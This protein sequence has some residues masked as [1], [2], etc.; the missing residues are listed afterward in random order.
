ME[1]RDDVARWFLAMVGSVLSQSLV[2]VQV[3]HPVVQLLRN[4]HDLQYRPPAKSADQLLDQLVDVG[5][6]IRLPRPDKTHSWAACSRARTGM[7]EILLLFAT[8]DLLLR[9]TLWV[10]PMP[11]HRARLTP[12]TNGPT[13]QAGP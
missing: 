10:V 9:A 7:K 6:G 8:I 2:Q 5:H 13:Q 12:R 4:R 3:A 1:R 11:V